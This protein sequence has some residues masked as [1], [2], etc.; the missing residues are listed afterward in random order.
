MFIYGM[1]SL[2]HSGSWPRVAWVAPR[3]FLFHLRVA[4]LPKVRDVFGHLPGALVGSEDVDEQRNAACGD[5]RCGLC[6]DQ[7]GEF[8]GEKRI[9]F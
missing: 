3:E 2:H 9:V 6:A 5:R 8:G 7:L 4:V 1:L